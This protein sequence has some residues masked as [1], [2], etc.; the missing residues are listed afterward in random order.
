[1]TRVPGAAP[2]R[3]V[4]V[5]ALGVVAATAGRARAGAW[6]RDQGHGYASTG[7]AGITATSVFANDYATTPIPRYAQNAWNGYGELG[8]GD[9]ANRGMFYGASF[10]FGTDTRVQVQRKILDQ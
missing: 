7:W 9:T 10:K 2:R 5:A 3:L 4:A 6:T 8:L 1:M